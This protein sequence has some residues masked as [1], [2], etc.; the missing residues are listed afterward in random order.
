VKK[1]LGMFLLSVLAVPSLAAAANFNMSGCGWG[2]T[3]F[4]ENNKGDQIL[5]ATTNGTFGNQTFGITSGT[6]NCTK[7]GMMKSEREQEVFVAMNYDSLTS[8]MARGKGETLA[9]F[10][11]L[12]GCSN[13]G[14]A[15]LA[16][17]TQAKYGTVYGK[18]ENAEAL[19]S[20]VR[21]EIAS[22]ATLCLACESRV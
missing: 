19:L 2:S 8:D 7:D 22:D 11:S 18:T 16:S 13:E 20:A 3:F 9:A 14:A 10:T 5:A 4:K 21:T 6:S 12:L 15:Q 17:V 1:V